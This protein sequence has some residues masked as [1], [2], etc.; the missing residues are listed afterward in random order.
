[1]RGRPLYV[2]W[3]ETAEEFK[4]MLDKERDQRRRAR[5][6][7]FW[8]LR[9]GKRISDVT[10][11]VGADYRTVQRWVA[12]YRVGGLDS[13]LR[14]TPGHAAPGRR[15]KLTAEQTQ[16]LL[17]EQEAGHFR[18]IRDAVDWTANTFGVDF[19]YTGMHAHLRRAQRRAS[20]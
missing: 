1:M 4:E 11:L 6:H 2:T 9:Q 8:M 18:T 14:R 20:A 10:E 17:T 13:V 5:L 19:T 3:N 15:S 7:A 16:A 12:W